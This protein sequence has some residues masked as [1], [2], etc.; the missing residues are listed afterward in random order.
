MEFITYTLFGSY[1]GMAIA[2]L[3]LFISFITSDVEENG[4]GAAVMAAIFL[5]LNYFWGNLPILEIFTFKN[6]GIYLLLGFIFSLI[7]TYFKGREISADQKKYFNLKDHVFRWIF[8]FPFSLI[9]WLFSSL[10]KD[11]FDKLWDSV[12]IVYKKLFGI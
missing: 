6:I 9:T 4:Y 10:L 1:I 8:L 12:E 5:G 11:L 2:L 7:R 3:I